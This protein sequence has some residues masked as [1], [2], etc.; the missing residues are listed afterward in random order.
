[1]ATKEGATLPTAYDTL[2]V[3]IALYDPETGAILDANERLEAIVG[4][5]AEELRD[6][7]VSDYTANTYSYSEPEFKQ[8][9]RAS[10]TDGPQQF[11]WRIKRADGELIWVQVDLSRQAD[12]SYVRAELREITDYYETYHRAEL[13]WRILRH[14]L[15]NEATIIEWNADKIAKNARTE[16][17]A[18]AGEMIASRVDNIGSIAESVKEIERAVTQPDTQRVRRHAARAVRT[19]ADDVSASYPAA[20]VTV[21]EREEMWAAVDDAFSH[22]LTHALENAIVHSE[23]AEPSVTVSVGPSPNTGRVEMQISDTNPPIPDD[24]INALSTPADISKTSHGSGVGLFVMKWCI[25]SLG[26]EIKFE[27]SGTRG[28]TVYFYLPPKAPPGEDR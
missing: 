20:T 17:A 19:V 25:E 6:R 21:D 10:A 4:Y 1:M 23:D 13:F 16:V 24:E 22:A 5:T 11:T 14:N 2:Q 28:N 7:S 15:R 18:E 12:H 27:R 9:L 3:G 26:G 8:R